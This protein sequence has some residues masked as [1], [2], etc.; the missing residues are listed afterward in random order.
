MDKI[1][2]IKTCGDSHCS[3]TFGN[4]THPRDWSETYKYKDEFLVEATWLGPKTMFGISKNGYDFNQYITSDKDLL[5]LFFGEIDCRFHVQ[6]QMKK[7]RNTEEILETLSQK[8]FEAILANQH[9]QIVVCG[10]LPSCNNEIV[11]Q[12]QEYCF[13]TNL[14][15]KTYVDTL[16]NKLKNW[17]EIH[18]VKYVYL[19]EGYADENGMLIHSLS[20]GW[21]HVADHEM[22]Y[23]NLRTWLKNN[24]LM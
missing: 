14:E 1:F 23:N 18:N 2:K 12:G 5:F 10:I 22:V 7:G 8:Y 9:N 15:R 13:G 16:N 19:Y 21:N 24:K 6:D 17:C 20:D 4:P 3:L 11:K